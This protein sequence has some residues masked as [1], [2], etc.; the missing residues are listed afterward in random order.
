MDKESLI[1]R[2]ENWKFIDAYKQ[3]NVIALTIRQWEA[4]KCLADLYGNCGLFEGG[5]G[6]SIG[7]TVELLCNE[8]GED[9]DRDKN[10]EDN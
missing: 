5:M 2:L 7:S 9:Y 10:T 4:I 3:S 6:E 8:I 1:N